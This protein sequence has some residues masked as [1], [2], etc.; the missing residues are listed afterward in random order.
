MWA[1]M[2]NPPELPIDDEAWNEGHIA[3]T[4]VRLYQHKN[5]NGK[6]VMHH[7]ISKIKQIEIG[8][9]WNLAQKIN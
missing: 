6:L 4:G 9:F 8:Q 5:R 3:S 7:K 2:I 1:I